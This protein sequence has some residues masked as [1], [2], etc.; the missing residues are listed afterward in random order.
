[1][2]PDRIIVILDSIFCQPNEGAVVGRGRVEE[3]G[4]QP[5]SLTG[6]NIN[7][8]VVVVFGFGGS[9]VLRAK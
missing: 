8:L 6:A 2:K 4:D 1:M 3:A 7:H 9:P 5:L